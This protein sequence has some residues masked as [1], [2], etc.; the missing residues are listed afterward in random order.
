MV[1]LKNYMVSDDFSH[2]K[3]EFYRT[4]EIIKMHTTIKDKMILN[5]C[6]GAGLH[7]GFLVRNGAQVI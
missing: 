1:N 2:H 4:Y 7:T 3:E 6:S 5:L